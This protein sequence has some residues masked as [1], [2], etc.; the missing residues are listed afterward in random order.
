MLVLVAEKKIHH[1][2]PTRTKK[3]LPT[4]PFN[5]ELF[6]QTHPGSHAW[7]FE[8]VVA[9]TVEHLL[10][11]STNKQSNK[12]DERLFGDLQRWSHAVEEQGRKT[13][14]THFL[15]WSSKWSDLLQRLHNASTRQEATTKLQDHIDKVLIAAL[16]GFANSAPRACPPACLGTQDPTPCTLQDLRNLRCK[17]GESSSLVW[18]VQN[19]I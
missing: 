18:R 3:S 16:H 15:L 12:E 1:H 4:L 2:R 8:Q 10:G 5:A 11:Q 7:D 13:L 14:H 17:D 6:V 19:W 9:I